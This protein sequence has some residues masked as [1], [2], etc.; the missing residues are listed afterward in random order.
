[1][2]WR[3]TDWP[4]YH[5]SVV[6]IQIK[7]APEGPGGA[8]LGMCACVSIC[9]RVCVSAYVCVC[10]CGFCVFVCALASLR[11]CVFA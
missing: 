7:D 3:C 1:M 8:E 2:R 6:R 9:V 5:Y 4:P 11:A 10:V